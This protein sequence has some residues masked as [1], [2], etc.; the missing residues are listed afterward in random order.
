MPLP[1]TSASQKPC[2]LVF[3]H[4]P[5][6]CLP[7]DFERIADHLREEA[8]W[9]RTW[10]LRDAP[11]RL[12]MP[13]LAFRPTYV[14]CPGPIK[15]L[16]P[17]RGTIGCG[18]NLG[19]AEEYRR[20]DAAG[21]PVPRWRLVTKGQTPN[22]D[23]FDDRVV[24]K[25]DFGGR[26]ADVMLMRKGKVRWR[27]TKSD[28]LSGPT[29]WIAQEFIDTGDPPVALRVATLFGEAIICRKSIGKKGVKETSH[30]VASNR[31]GHH[32]LVTDDEVIHFAEKAHAAFPEIPVLGFDVVRCRQTQ[33]LF[34]LEANAIGLVWHFSSPMGLEI[35]K[36]FGFVYEDQFDAMRKCARIFAKKI[37]QL[38]T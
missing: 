22:L 37:P 18:I 4:K 30:I 11:H 3:L 35:Q 15:R 20:L 25:P 12:K 29:N 27:E 13:S 32:E 6:V 1:T 14:F 7:G 24:M 8:P 28:Y 36:Q 31:S 5:H 26:G 33:K 16:K 38:A 19:K 17:W 9:I 21:I 23:D 10:V 34:I 2:H